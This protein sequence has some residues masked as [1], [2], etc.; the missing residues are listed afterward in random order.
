[1]ISIDAYR[2]RI[3]SFQNDRSKQ[4]GSSLNLNE[5]P[6]MKD[7][8]HSPGLTRIFQS[9]KKSCFL[10]L[11]CF[12]L[13]SFM[14]KETLT[15]GKSEDSQTNL[16]CRILTPMESKE[17]SISFIAH[18]AVLASKLLIGNIEPHP[19][20]SDLKE[21]LGFL[22]TDTEEPNI[23]EVLNDFKAAQDKA[24]NLKKLKTKKVDNLKATLAYLNDWDKDEDIINEEIESYTKDGIALLVLKKIYAMAP[25]RCASCL[26]T[27]YFKPGEHCTLTCF[28]CNTGACKDCYDK[29]EEKLK[30]CSMFNKNVCNK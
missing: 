3:G 8:Q 7:G 15:E 14:C 29:D 20:P 13:L 30:S 19:G 2:A 23:K 10:I 28:R 11:V 16:S 17:I 24:T 18:A 6:F 22:Y 27:Y 4:R 21:F 5:F 9:Q 1:M 26:K 12:V 25:E